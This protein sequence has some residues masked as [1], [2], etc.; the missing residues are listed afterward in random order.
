[1]H[2]FLEK[3]RGEIRS[4]RATKQEQMIR[5]LNPIIR[6]WA[7]YHRH[8]EAGST[9]RKVRMALWHSLWRWAT[10][11]HPDKSSTWIL[12][13]SIN[14]TVDIT[15]EASTSM[16]QHRSFSMSFRLEP[17]AIISSVRFSA[18]NK[19]SACDA[20]LVAYRKRHT[21]RGE[22]PHSSPSFD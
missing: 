22:I 16:E 15:G 7:Y 5:L 18:A 20:V 1:M 14:K 17:L 3:V 4:N 2:A 6:G 11:R 13:R 8:I 9:Y 10:R 21:D 19:D 12:N